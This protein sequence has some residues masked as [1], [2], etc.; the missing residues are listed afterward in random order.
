MP[1]KNN[2]ILEKLVEFQFVYGSLMK[3][4]VYI[5]AN[6]NI[7]VYLGLLDANIGTPLV[8]APVVKE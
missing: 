6:F 8:F 1:K 4:F 7:V 3:M 5:Y 2:I